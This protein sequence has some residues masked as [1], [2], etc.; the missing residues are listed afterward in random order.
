MTS[1][2]RLTRAAEAEWLERWTAGPSEGGGAALPAGSPAPDLVLLDDEGRSRRLS[3][4]WAAGPALVMFWRHFGCNCGVER[5]ARLRAEWPGYVEAGLTPVVVAQGEPLRAAAY[6]T[7]HALPCPVLCDPD[8]RAYRA[9]GLGHWDVAQVLFDAPEAFWD[10]PREL[11]ARF[12][13]ERRSTGR[14]PVDDPWRR[15][16]EH[17]VVDGVVRLTH[18]YQHCEDFPEP[19]VLTAAARLARTAA[20]PRVRVGPFQDP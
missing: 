16:A 11:G 15:A 9:Y 3:D 20:D 4:F 2:A 12:Q 19:R 18:A 17:V 8:H 13:A 10:H 1:L 6:R 5:A 7:E 14:P